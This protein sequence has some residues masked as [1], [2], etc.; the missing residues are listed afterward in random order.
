MEHDVRAMRAEDYD[1]VIALWQSCAG[2]GLSDSDSREAIEAYL[3]RNPDMSAVARDAEGRLVGA[4]LCG[5]DGRRGT[6]Y[7]LAVSA[8]S[9]RHGIA[10]ALL[11]RCFARLGARR[12]PKCNIFVFHDNTDGVEFWLRA[13]WTARGDLAVLQRRVD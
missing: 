12:I 9:R 13:G 5:D 11:R 10:T 1:E 7:H 6:L 2:I 3:L 8:A 4:V